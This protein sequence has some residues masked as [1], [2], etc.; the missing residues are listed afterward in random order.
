MRLSPDQCRFG[1]LASQIGVPLAPDQIALLESF[2]ELLRD[3]AIPLGLVSDRDAGRLRDRHLLDCLRASL[4][5]GRFDRDA[6]D[7]GS[8]AGLPG[9]VVAIARPTVRMTLLEPKRR[10]AAFLEL[11]IADLGLGNVSVSIERAQSLSKPSPADICFARAVAPLPASLALARPLLR[12]GG[13]LVYFASH[14][15]RAAAV[16]EEIRSTLILWTPL[17]ERSGPLVIMTR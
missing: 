17:L 4:A 12:P 16:P 15:F 5:V 13:R 10:S 2:E 6:Y 8:G 3:R 11:A 7:I 9:L 1:A 14:D